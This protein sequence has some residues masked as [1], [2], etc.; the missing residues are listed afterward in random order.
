MKPLPPAVPGTAPGPRRGVLRP[1]GAA[2]R[3]ASET[4]I[5]DPPLPLRRLLHRIRRAFRMRPG[6]PPRRLLILGDANGAL[7]PFAARLGFSVSAGPSGNSP[8]RHE[9][10]KNTKNRLV[11]P[12]KNTSVFVTFVPSCLRGSLPAPGPF[13]AVADP[14]AYAR[15][16]R[17]DW[18]RYR[19]AVLRLLAPD[20]FLLLS[21]P[22]RKPRLYSRQRKLRPWQFRKDPDRPGRRFDPDEIAWVFEGHFETIDRLEEK[23]GLQHTHHILLHRRKGGVT[24]PLPSVRGPLPR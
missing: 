21:V 4:K 5:P 23:T 12:A 24:P 13:D 3:I 11:A 20:G 22:G 18:W 19:R 6:S 9:G 1:S 2:A 15:L 10:T 7:A 16:T 8:R 17:R 14:G